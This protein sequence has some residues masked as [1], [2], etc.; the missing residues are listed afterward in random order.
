M[1]HNPDPN[2]SIASI[3]G[4][5]RTL[6]DWTTVFN[7]AAILLPPRPGASAF[8]PVIERIF[9]TLSDADVRTTIW[10]PGPES[11]ARKILGDLADR[12]LVW[13]DPTSSFAK[14]LGIESLPAFVHLRQ[15]TTLVAASQ[16]FSAT[17][18]QK[19][20]DGIAK[21]T[22]WIAPIVAGKRN[23]PSTPGWALSA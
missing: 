13:C 18:W 11:M 14:S 6:D 15:D 8:C 16:G 5:A 10:I 7:V 3:K 22:H 23:P 12:Y 19:V 17:E 1:A 20:A 9:A 2:L 21:H 4:T